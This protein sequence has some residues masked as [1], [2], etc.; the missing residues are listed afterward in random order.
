MSS[1]LK[2]VVFLATP[3]VCSS[4]CV[5]CGGSLCGSVGPFPPHN[6]SNVYGRQW[7]EEL[8]RAFER[9]LFYGGAYCIWC[10]W[11]WWYGYGGMEVWSSPHDTQKRAWNE[12]GIGAMAMLMI[13]VVATAMM[14]MTKKMAA[15]VPAAMLENVREV[16]GVVHGGVAEELQPWRLLM[17]MMMKTIYEEEEEELKKIQY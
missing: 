13:I 17:A 4:F 16:V 3:S 11:W 9:R 15:M 14:L 1:K 8:T 5:P 2:G 12:K 6:T 7:K 10:I